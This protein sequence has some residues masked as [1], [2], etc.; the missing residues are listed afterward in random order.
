[1]NRNYSQT[2]QVNLRI[3]TRLLIFV[4]IEEIET[5]FISF[6]NALDSKI[7]KNYGTKILAAL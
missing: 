7:G 3:F 4:P 2:T 5:S 1:M 6:E